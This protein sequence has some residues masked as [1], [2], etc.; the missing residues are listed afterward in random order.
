MNKHNT[1]ISSSIMFSAWLGVLLCMPAREALAQAALDD[2]ETVVKEGLAQSATGSWAEA[3]AMFQRAN[4]VRPGP[5]PLRGMALALVQLRRYVESLDCAKRALG[6]HDGIHDGTHDDNSKPL[7]AAMRKE[8]EALRDKV[9]AFV[10]HVKLSTQPANAALRVD[11]RAYDTHEF[12]LDEGD[13]ELAV[14]ADGYRE[15]TGTLRARIGRP[16]EL[17]VSLEALAVSAKPESKALVPAPAS[18]HR[19]SSARFGERDASARAK[20]AVTPA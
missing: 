12:L 3:Y 17:V 14:S 18:I 4:E 8:L 10:V 13:Y 15:H 11:G 7:T 9:Q 20:P 5:R 2:Y 6:T 19:A 16:L 1:V